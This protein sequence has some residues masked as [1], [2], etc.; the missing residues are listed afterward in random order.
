M[1]QKHVARS[2]MA[3]VGQ[4]IRC[5]PSP[6][7]ESHLKLRWLRFTGRNKQEQLLQRDTFFGDRIN[8]GIRNGTYGGASQGRPVLITY[9]R[10]R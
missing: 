9:T 4:L 3:S 2:T 1:G 5:L 6:L 10:L 7:A 8:D